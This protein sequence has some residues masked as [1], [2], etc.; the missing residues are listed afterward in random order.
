VIA[1]ADQVWWYTARATG[2][3]LWLLLA[4]SLLWGFGVS[5][6]VV[7]RRGVPA[8]MLALH[9]HLAMLAVVA[10]GGHLAALWADSY[11]EFGW[12]ELF[13]PMASAWRPGAVAWGVVALYLLVPVVVTSWVMRR[14]PRRVWHAVHLLSLPLLVAAS[15]HGITAGA[16][17]PNPAVRA[18]F[19]AVSSAVVVLASVR[20]VRPSRR[21]TRPGTVAGQSVAN[22]GFGRWRSNQATMSTT[23]PVS[24]TR[25]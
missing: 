23:A 17:W 4:A 21:P 15:V 11:V 5:S 7:R 18:T 25:P 9:R 19:V 6:R 24:G 2:L 10:T 8:W 13:V 12:R 3:V 22:S 14:L 1:V 16:D 20:A